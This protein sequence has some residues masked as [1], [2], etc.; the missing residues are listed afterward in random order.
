M[1]TQDSMFEQNQ[2]ERFWTR[3][4][5]QERQICPCCKRLAVTWRLRIHSTLV[6]M[7]IKLYRVSLADHGKPDGWV[8]LNRFA[9]A[10]TGNDFSIV[11]HWHLAE[12]MPAD[13]SE[14]KNSSGFYRLREVG[15]EFVENK[16]GIPKYMFVFDNKVVRPGTDIIWV[17][18][19]LKKGFKY[20]DLMEGSA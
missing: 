14:D 12:A 13:E 16:M 7:L 3:L 17:K 4:H 1:T 5:N 15:V 19:A 8:H 9:P 2:Y 20:S 6:H 10:R 11:K 18:D